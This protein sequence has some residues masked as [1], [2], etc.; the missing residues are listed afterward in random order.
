MYIFW[1]IF[2]DVLFWYSGKYDPTL[3]SSGLKLVELLTHHNKEY[4]AK[5]RVGIKTDTYDITGKVIDERKDF[6]L[7]EE[8]LKDAL[9][10]FIGEYYQTVPIYSSIKVN[11]KKLYEYA[12]NNEE[13]SLPKHLVRISDISLLEIT[14]DTFTFKVN[15]SSGTYIRSLINDIGEKLSIPMTM[16]E[17][18][19]TRVG[20]YSIEESCDIDNLKVIPIIDSINIK[21]IEVD[22]FLLKKVSNGVRIDNIYNEDMVMFTYQNS[23]V[24]IYVKDNNILKSYRVFNKNKNE[25]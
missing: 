15:V 17:L 21:K 6:I 2:P 19:R 24:S 10:S 16:E 5:V 23:P 3:P 22:E 1:G 18:K 13:V 4:I 7:N 11:G 20:D 8:V 14:R 25:L 9:N 12:R